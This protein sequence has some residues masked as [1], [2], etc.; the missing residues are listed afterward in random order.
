MH[1]RVTRPTFDPATVADAS[2]EVTRIEPLSW[3]TQMQT[4]LQLLV[5]GER[6]SDYGVRIE[7][8]RGVKVAETHKA[9]SHNYL[10]VDIAI[11][12]AAAPGT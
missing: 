4:P 9:D 10:F 2:G 7:G 6:I 8:G 1:S 12:A 11:N 5:A 3:W